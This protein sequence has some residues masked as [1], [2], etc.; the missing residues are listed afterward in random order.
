MF[1]RQQPRPAQGC[2]PVFLREPL[3]SLYA[4]IAIVQLAGLN[5][6]TFDGRLP[7]FRC[8]I[9]TEQLVKLLS[10]LHLVDPIPWPAALLEIAEEF[11][12]RFHRNAKRALRKNHDPI[13]KT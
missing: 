9:V 6:L 10:G 8:R 4:R 3:V 12:A 7:A 1:R 13:S 2:I 11:P 5:E